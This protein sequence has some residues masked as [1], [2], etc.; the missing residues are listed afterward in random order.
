MGE[1]LNLHRVKENLKKNNLLESK[2]PHNV[3]TFSLP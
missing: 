2:N 1:Q 3:Y